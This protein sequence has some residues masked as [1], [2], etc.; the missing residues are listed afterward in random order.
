MGYRL[1]IGERLPDGL[2]RVAREQ[3][4]GAIASLDVTHAQ[5]ADGIHDARK[6]FKK[7]R[8]L[9]RLASGDLDSATASAEDTAIRDAGRA[10]A[11]ARDAEA[12][13][14]AFDTMCGRDRGGEPVRRFAAIRR[15]LVRDRLAARQRLARDD[16]TIEGVV[17]S[18]VEARERAAAWPLDRDSFAAIRPGLARAYA[19]GRAN[20]RRLPPSPSPEQLHDFRK[21]VK[22]LWYHMRLLQGVWPRMIKRQA[23]ELDAL[24]ELLGEDHDLAVLR[25]RVRERGIR[26]AEALADLIEKRRRDLLDDARRLAELLYS[27]KPR[28]FVARM[29]RYWKASRAARHAANATEAKVRKPEV[30]SRAAAPR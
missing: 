8:A 11:D 14:A 23:A 28:S 12:L 26:G 15:A 3:L 24:G 27:E 20:L 19:R 21:R 30:T 5:R 13:L 1:H 17:A 22:E 16:G 9:L 2:R 29:G 18:L 25:D 7:V 4:E 6:R 10:L